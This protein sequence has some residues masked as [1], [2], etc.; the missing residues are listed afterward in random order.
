MSNILNFNGGGAWNYS[1]PSKESYM[2]SITGT[3]VEISEVQ[4]TNFQT[5]QPEYWQDGNPKLNIQLT[6]QGQ[7]GKELPWVFSPKSLGMDA[8][9]AAL[10]AYKP[11]SNSVADIGGLLV[12]VSTQGDSTQYHANNPRPWNVRILGQGNAPFRGVK[13]FKAAPSVQQVAQ[14]PM[15]QAPQQQVPPSP[16]NRTFSGQPQQSMHQVHQQ[17]QQPAQQ[18]QQ[19]VVQQPM[20]QPAQQP[21]HDTGAAYYDEEIPF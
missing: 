10:Q 13:E 15:Q 19:Q 18:Y 16:L 17:M 20:Q 11:D 21:M 2:P 5:R 1:D 8:V 6:I 14:Q 7:S 12:E 9:K 3:V 4:S